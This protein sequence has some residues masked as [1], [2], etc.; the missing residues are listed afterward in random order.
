MR[1]WFSILIMVGGGLLFASGCG[2]TNKSDDDDTGPDGDADADADGDSDGDC[3]DLDGDGAG[4]G[5]DCDADDC[6]DTDPGTVDECGQDCGVNPLRAGC[7]CTDGEV[8]ACYMGPPGT[9]GNGICVPG[10]KECV[11]DAWGPCDGQVLPQ[12]AV[13][14]ECDYE[15]DNCDGTADEGLL[16]DCGDCNPECTVSC[17]GV[18]C[19]DGFDVEDGRSIVQNPDGT[20]TLGGSATV[21]NF[22]IWVANSGE[23]TV[24]KID[25]RT[26]EEEGR[27]VTMPP[28]VASGWSA[29]PSRTTVNPHG[30]VVVSNRHETAG[31]GGST[32]IM[33]SDCPDRNGNG[34]ADTSSGAGDIMEWGEDECQI[35]YCDDIPAARGSAF[36]IRAELDA[37]IHEF[38][39]V[40]AYSLMNTYTGT[41]YEIDSVTGEK[42]G[43][44]IEDTPAYGLA[45][46]PNGL[47]WSVGLGGCPRSTDTTT[48]E[49]TA[50]EGCGGA[51]GIA[52]DSEGRVWIG[53]SVSRLTP[54]D[55]LWEYPLDEDGNQISVYGGGITVD[56]FGN[57]FTGEWGWGGPGSAYK[58]DG[59][60][61]VVTLLP[62]MGGHGWAVDFDGY[63][64]SVDMQDSA[65]V[66]DPETLEVEDVRPPFVSPYTYSDMT[67]FQLQNTVTPAGV[68][69]RLFETCDADKQLHLASLEWVADVP[70]GSAITFRLKHADSIEELEAGAWIDVASV[71]PDE[72]PVDLDAVLREAGVDTAALGRFVRIEVTLQSVDR[73]NRPT[74][75]SFGIYY[76]CLDLFG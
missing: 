51:Y 28:E 64:W 37:G 42:T 30:D 16:S 62:G 12:A 9:G 49:Q 10:L 6:D 27:Y 76:S 63:I 21:S 1:R 46:G 61:M 14:T 20:I 4:Q 58:I 53:S 59:E 33:A 26:H 47:L 73:L 60:T 68:Y 44:E 25:T 48:L 17:V 50:Y 7:P 34:I 3:V 40:G 52:V 22:V 29:S 38:V 66:M 36:E 5:D 18:D 67:G 8:T 57:A 69:E 72:S 19:E 54:E 23:G 55:D 75:T 15:D 71:P 45:M 39:W 11:G 56:A 24:S 2:G 70:A 32:K 74:L 31:G 35:W 41:I 13:E 65:H 43:R